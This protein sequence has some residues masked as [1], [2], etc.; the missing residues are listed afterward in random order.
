MA[1]FWGLKDM[2]NT[3]EL[4]DLVLL[5]LAAVTYILF[6]AVFAVLCGSIFFVASYVRTYRLQ[7]MENQRAFARDSSSIEKSDDD[8][9][10]RN[11]QTV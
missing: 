5:G 11:L 4:W 3:A 10:N 7:R 2:E 1:F 8:S 9:R 6:A